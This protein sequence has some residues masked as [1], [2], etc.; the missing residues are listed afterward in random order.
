MASVLSVLIVEDNDANRKELDQFFRELGFTTYMAEN[1]R[2][3]I[4]FLSNIDD[5]KYPSLISSDVNM[6]EMDGIMLLDNLRASKKFSKIPFM[7]ITA[8]KDELLKMAA[9]CLDVNAF[10]LKPPD[11]ERIIP[12]LKK[13]FPDHQF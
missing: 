1:G 5:N 4:T 10:Y 13:L 7:V 8:N 6:P 9:Q 12:E 2:A 11:Y 3:A